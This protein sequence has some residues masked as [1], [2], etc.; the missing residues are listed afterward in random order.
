MESV[1]QI[2]E[3]AVSRY[4]TLQLVNRLLRL[5]FLGNTV[6]FFLFF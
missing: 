6:T 1:S 2:A 5:G 4:N 3:S